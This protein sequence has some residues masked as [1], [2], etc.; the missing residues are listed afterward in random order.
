[1]G[2]IR[3]VHCMIWKWSK[4]RGNITQDRQ[5][6]KADRYL[7][8]LKQDL[9]EMPG[10]ARSTFY[11]GQAYL[12]KYLAGGDSN[13]AVQ[14]LLHAVEYFKQRVTMQ[15]GQTRGIKAQGMEM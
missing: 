9:A 6:S 11:I 12:D 15:T 8:W 3:L 13:E 1:M 2:D 7:A 5:G 14:S 4:H 10:D